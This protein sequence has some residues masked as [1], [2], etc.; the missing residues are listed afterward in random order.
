MAIS[1]LGT[2]ARTIIA[3]TLTNGGLHSFFTGSLSGFLYVRSTAVV[4]VVLGRASAS[5]AALQAQSGTDF[6]IGADNFDTVLIYGNIGDEIVIDFIPVT[7][8]TATTAP[9]WLNLA[10]YN[11]GGNQSGGY[12]SQPTKIIFPVDTVSASNALPSGRQYSSAAADSGVAGYLFGGYTAAATTATNSIDRYTVPTDV[13]STL[14][15]TLSST[16][17]HGVS[18]ANSATAAYQSTG[19]FAGSMT[20][21]TVIER[22]AFPTMTR[23][24]ASATSLSRLYAWACANGHDSGYIFGGS[25]TTT[26]GS[27]Q[28]NVRR[29]YFS[30]D[31]GVTVSGLSMTVYNYLSVASHHGICAVYTAGTRTSASGGQATYTPTWVRTWQ[32][33]T[34]VQVELTPRFYKPTNLTYGGHGSGAVVNANSGTATYF[35]GG[36]DGAPTVVQSIEK[37]DMPSLT[38][39][40]I[41][42]TSSQQQ[43]GVY[44][45]AQQ[46][47]DNIGVF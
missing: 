12:T 3:T 41:L 34:D 38:T 39:R 40:I 1:S 30:T 35:S 14:T 23:T 29:H 2:T 4:T 25:T 24:T 15:A 6:S 46:G 7:T 16:R 10:G 47:F 36:E 21:N 28:S 26:A 44:Y 11:F 32:Y 22:F 45:N 31:V 43:A 13:A 5:A 19:Y 18:Y 17:Y 37:M 33:A 20:G 9:S 42:L 27:D 8:S